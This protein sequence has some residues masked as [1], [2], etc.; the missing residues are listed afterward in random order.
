MKSSATFFCLALLLCQGVS[1]QQQTPSDRIY[2]LYRTTY[3]S[4]DGRIHIAT[5]DSQL[6]EKTNQ[7]NC[8]STADLWTKQEKSVKFWCEKGRFKD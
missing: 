8:Q 2:T 4:Q 7:I 3:G 6:G 1:A 5:F